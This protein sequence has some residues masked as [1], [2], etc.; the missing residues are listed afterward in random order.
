MAKRKYP[1]KLDDA[2]FGQ[3]EFKRL[4]KMPDQLEI[5]VGIQVKIVDRDFPERLEVHLKAETD[6]DSPLT[7]R[8]VVIGL[9]SLIKGEPEP[10]PNLI[11][12]FVVDRALYM[13]WS[14][15]D[16]IVTQNTAKMGIKPIR[17]RWPIDFDYEPPAELL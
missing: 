11:Q 4:P 15:I 3:L 14:Y 6:E 8:V 17:L 7:I 5:Y 16:H 2:F 9:F 13:L 12:D 10:E 1:L